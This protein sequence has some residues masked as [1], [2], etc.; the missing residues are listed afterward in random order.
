MKK[1]LISLIAVSLIGCGN[2]LPNTYAV[3]S[4][5]PVVSV[6][7]IPKGYKVFSIDYYYSTVVL[8]KNIPDGKYYAWRYAVDT[9]TI[10]ETGDSKEDSFKKKL[11]FK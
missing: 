5:T 10:Y 7:Q 3:S 1:Y 9:L 2:N 6:V 8:Q 4:N 11:G